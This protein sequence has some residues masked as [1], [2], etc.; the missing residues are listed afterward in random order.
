MLKRHNNWLK[1]KTGGSLCTAQR[2]Y[3]DYKFVEIIKSHVT[4][5]MV[6]F[7]FEMANELTEEMMLL[8]YKTAT[9]EFFITR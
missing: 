2:D 8:L 1:L 7:I 9:L 6:N 3:R 5:N 4:T